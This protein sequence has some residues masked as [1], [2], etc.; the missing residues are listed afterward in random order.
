MKLP[1]RIRK[2]EVNDIGIKLEIIPGLPLQRQ[3][4]AVGGN[5]FE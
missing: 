5:W 1:V 2:S 4:L 3:M